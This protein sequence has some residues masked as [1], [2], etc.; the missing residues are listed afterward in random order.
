[1][2]D[3][4][5]TSERQHSILLSSVLHLL[6]GVL[7]LVFFVLVPVELGFL[8]FQGKKLYGRFSLEGIVQYREPLSV[9]Q[10]ATLAIPLF[11]WS[12]LMMMLVC[13]RVSV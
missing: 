3:F 2:A 9:W 8:Q 7:I 12:G 5:N 11:G 10:Y 13:V 6:P 1:M 4:K